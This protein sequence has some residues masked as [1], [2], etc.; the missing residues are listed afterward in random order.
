MPVLLVALEV[1]SAFLAQHQR[2]SKVGRTVGTALS[3]PY[4]T[5]EDPEAR[6][7]QGQPK[8]TQAAMDRGRLTH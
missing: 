6:Y 4:F 8:V 2:L 3:N 7:S 1:A 5:D